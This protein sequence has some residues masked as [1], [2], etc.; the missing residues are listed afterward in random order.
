MTAPEYV[1]D[2]LKVLLLL[3]TVFPPAPAALVEIDMF[4]L[5][6]RFRAVSSQTIF[7]HFPTRVS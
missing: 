2:D 3:T 5:G 7:F 1:L 4:E 6:T